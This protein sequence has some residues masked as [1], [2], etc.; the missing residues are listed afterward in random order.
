MDINRQSLELELRNNL[1]KLALKTIKIEADLK[2]NRLLKTND[3]GITELIDSARIM[4]LSNYEF[5]RICVNSYNRVYLHQIGI[6]IAQDIKIFKELMNLGL[7]NEKVKKQKKTLNS[8]LVFVGKRK[9][10]KKIKQS[11]KLVFGEDCPSDFRLK[12]KLN[13]S[14]IL[15]TYIRCYD[16]YSCQYCH[17]FYVIN[18]S[19]ETN[20][21]G[22]DRIGSPCINF[23]RL[24]GMGFGESWCFLSEENADES[25]IDILNYW[26]DFINSAKNFEFE[27]I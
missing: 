10:K 19:D 16:G 9:L 5:L 26:K 3:T 8:Q 20:E 14:L 12:V 21:S 4:G 6:D 2:L 23:P 13:Q 11:W 22:L 25:I 24:L 7:T 15:S 18:N 1:Y 17:E 27:S